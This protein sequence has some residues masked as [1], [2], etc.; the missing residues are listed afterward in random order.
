M[1]ATSATSAVLAERMK[2]RL[3]LVEQCHKTEGT[4]KHVSDELVG[5]NL[6]IL[7]GHPPDLSGG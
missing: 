3:D 4:I 1:G 7:S 5:I 6:T 2:D